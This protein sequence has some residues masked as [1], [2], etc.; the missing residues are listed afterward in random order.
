MINVSFNNN[1]N[2]LLCSL[3]T[4]SHITA[5]AFL[6]DYLEPPLF[7]DMI[8]VELVV[9]RQSFYYGKFVRVYKQKH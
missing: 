9:G 2:V 3:Q 8:I 1:N 5:Q 7:W 4:R 6:Y